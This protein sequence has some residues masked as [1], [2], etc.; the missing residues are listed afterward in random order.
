MEAYVVWD[1]VVYQTE[2]DQS[3]GKPTLAI[4]VFHVVGG[5]L[6]ES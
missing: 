4:R 1:P 6:S 3:T 2:V 5:R